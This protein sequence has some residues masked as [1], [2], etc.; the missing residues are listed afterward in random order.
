MEMLRTAQLA[1]TA[2]QLTLQ[3]PVLDTLRLQDVQHQQQVAPPPPPPAIGSVNST[4]Q[5][6]NVDA[7]A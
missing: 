3:Q 4:S 1:D 5:G 7:W 2:V 6:R